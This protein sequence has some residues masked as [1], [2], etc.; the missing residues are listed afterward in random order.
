M[1]VGDLEGFAPVARAVARCIAV[2]RQVDG[3]G[4]DQD[5][6]ASD[7]TIRAA[8][9]REEFTKRHFFCTP[10]EKRYAKKAIWNA[11]KNACRRRAI[12][13]KIFINKDRFPHIPYDF[14]AHMEARDVIRRLEAKLQEKELQLLLRVAIESTLSDAYNPELDQCGID[15]FRNRVRAV[16]QKAKEALQWDKTS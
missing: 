13:Q 14:E 10:A 5:D 2:S 11:A 4:Y 9:A 6:Y 3:L 12:H 1:N 7:F 8:E 15:Q 16:R